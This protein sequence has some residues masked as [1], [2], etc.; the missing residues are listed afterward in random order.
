MLV[1]AGGCMVNNTSVGGRA[2][3]PFLGFYQ[4]TKAAVIH[5]G[6]VWRLEM[7]PLGVRVITLVTGGIATKFIDNQPRVPLPPDSY[8]K[9][10]RDVIEARPAQVPLGMDPDKFAQSVVR[11]VE[12]GTTG[13]V[14]IGGGASVLR[15]LLWLLPQSL[16]DF[17]ALKFKPFAKPLAEHH[18]GRS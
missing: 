14:W 11:H 12:R 9:C 13:K 3:V 10:V 2:P 8:Y 4:A 15:L 16:V 17:V 6:E 1:E 18:H 7:A 5:A